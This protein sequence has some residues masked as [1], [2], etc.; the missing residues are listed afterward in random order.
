MSSVQSFSGFES[1]GIPQYDGTVLSGDQDPFGHFEASS[2][3]FLG[4]L[5]VEGNKLADVAIQAFVSFGVKEGDVR[6][7]PEIV[8][9]GSMKIVAID[10]SANGLFLGRL[11]QILQRRAD[12]PEWLTCKVN[13]ERMDLLS[14][15]TYAAY[16]SMVSEARTRSLLLPDSVAVSHTNDEPWTA[17]MLTGEKLPEPDRIHVA[18]VSSNAVSSVSHNTKKGGK[19]IRIRLSMIV[20]TFATK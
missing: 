3:H 12:E 10:G 1:E 14:A 6:F 4:L 5:S 2:D 19:S 17:T 7:V 11:P 9:D 20:D 15:T 16:W 8:A 13:N 18:S